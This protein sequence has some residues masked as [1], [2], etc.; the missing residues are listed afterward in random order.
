MTQEDILQNPSEYDLSIETVGVGTLKS[1]MKGIQFTSDSE[2]VSL[3]TDVNR[4]KHFYETNTPVPSLEAAGP[5]ETIFHDPAWTRAG[6]VTC[7]GLCPGLNSVIK[8]LVQTLWFDYGVRNIFGIPYGYRGLN[9]QYGYSPKVLNPD[10]VDAIQEDGGT[11]LGSSRGNQ[12]AAVMVDTLM[13]LNINV[14]FCI[15]GDGTLRGAHDIAE[16][17]KKRKQPI[18]VIGIPKTIDNDLNLIDRTFGFETAVL[19]ATD[20][21][22]CA[23]NEANGAFNGL[24]LVKLMG[25]DSGFIAAYAALATTVVNICLVPEVPFTLEGLCKA[26]ESRYDN[27]KTHAVIAVAEGAGQELFNDQPERKDA[28]GN[29]LKND[30]GE[31]LT[32]KIKE[33]FK[34]VGKE[35]NIKYFDPSYMVRSTPAKGTDAIFC[36]QLAEAAVH[37]GMAGKT[38][39]VVGSMNNVFSH[40]PI[41]YAV[42]ERKKINPN[43]TLWHAVLGM[44]RQQDYFSGKGKGHK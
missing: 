38:D 24:G 39:M 36:F 34:N 9:P 31:F 8:G 19:S 44:T 18:S 4:L 43:G 1:P 2:Q 30:I 14:L 40:V 27:G 37:A 35:I 15:G 13:R 5:R 20:V 10:V 22:T 3:T 32:R 28:S 25:R 7:G 21:I 33:H 26:L 12:D 6:I 11:I 29:I 16:E 41:E 23:H 42:N 17:V